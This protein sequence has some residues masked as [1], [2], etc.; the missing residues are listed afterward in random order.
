VKTCRVQC[1]PQ[2]VDENSLVKYSLW[3]QPRVE[4]EEVSTVANFTNS[5]QSQQPSTGGALRNKD[6][7]RFLKLLDGEASDHFANMRRISE[8]DWVEVCLS[9][10]HLIEKFIAHLLAVVGE[11]ASLSETP[12]CA[13]TARRVAPHDLIRDCLLAST[14]VCECKVRM[15]SRSEKPIKSTDR[16]PENT[17]NIRKAEAQRKAI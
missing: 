7:L 13:T 8:A 2:V 16:D 4:A 3:G 11:K 15:N 6:M 9:A 17:K 1:L 5:F 14:A 12:S 10:V